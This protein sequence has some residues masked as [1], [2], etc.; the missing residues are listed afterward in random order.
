MPGR[1]THVRS[2]TRILRYGAVGY[3]DQRRA[4]RA[5]ACSSARTTSERA[6]PRASGVRRALRHGFRGR[7]AIQPPQPEPVVTGSAC[8]RGR[9]LVAGGPHFGGAFYPGLG[10]QV[11]SD[12]RTTFDTALAQHWSSRL[13][14][15][16]RDFEAG[17]EC[18]LGH[19]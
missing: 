6:R 15:H 2:G 17:S 1:F 16:E 12:E 9:T 14:R 3:L 4:P 7:L 18:D 19:R 5:T 11:L 13:D 8:Q 10:D